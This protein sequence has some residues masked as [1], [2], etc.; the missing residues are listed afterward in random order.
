MK[1]LNGE[2][3]R[4]FMIEVDARSYVYIICGMEFFLKKESTFSSLSS[5]ILVQASKSFD[6]VLEFIMKRL[7]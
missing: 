7:E 3:C 6:M 2:R 5:L 4:E 1:S